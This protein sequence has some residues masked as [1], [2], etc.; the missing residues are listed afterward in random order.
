MERYSIWLQ[1]GF[2]PTDGP[3]T[4]HEYQGY[5]MDLKDNLTP[6]SCFICK[7]V[8]EGHQADAS[9]TEKFNKGNHHIG[10][11]SWRTF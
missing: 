6:A 11:Y 8:H 7:I 1:N 2:H 4:T 10:Q 3:A 5:H 9:A